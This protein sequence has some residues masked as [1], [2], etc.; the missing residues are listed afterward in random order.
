MCGQQCQCQSVRVAGHV[1]VENKS[2]LAWQPSICLRRLGAATDIRDHMACSPGT[3]L[4]PIMTSLR[5]WQLNH[6]RR[7]KDKEKKR[8]G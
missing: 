5:T 1:L 8:L 3:C 4:V 2:N 7:P 6:I